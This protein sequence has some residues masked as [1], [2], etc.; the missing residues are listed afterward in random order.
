MNA[1]ILVQLLEVAFEMHFG[2]GLKVA[3]LVTDSLNKNT[4]TV[5]AGKQPHCRIGTDNRTQVGQ[6]L[7]IPIVDS[8]YNVFS[9]IRL[10]VG[11]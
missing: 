1:P 3:V 10:R 6:L 9:R 2:L 5:A 11:R 8:L 7:E 4:F